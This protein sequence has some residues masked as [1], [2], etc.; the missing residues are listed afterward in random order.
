MDGVQLPQGCRA[1]T[2]S[3]FTFY[4]LGPRNFW[5]SFDR[6]RK[7]ERL[8]RPWSHP[9]VLNTG[10]LDGESSALTTRPLLNCNNFINILF[11]H[12]YSWPGFCSSKIDLRSIRFQTSE[13]SRFARMYWRLAVTKVLQ[14]LLKL[15]PVTVCKLRVQRQQFLVVV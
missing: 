15:T 6:P 12:T 4:H 3:Q 5:Y 1:T 10:P 11:T 7:D 2:R 9:A 13:R 8:S 14:L